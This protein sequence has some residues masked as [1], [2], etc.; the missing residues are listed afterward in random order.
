MDG[1]YADP[2]MLTDKIIGMVVGI[3]RADA[4]IGGEA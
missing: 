1:P 4:Q 2:L 3:Y